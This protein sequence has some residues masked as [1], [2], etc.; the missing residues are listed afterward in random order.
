MMTQLLTSST[1]T[2]SSEEIQKILSKSEGSM[3]KTAQLQQAL[4][5][6]EATLS[7]KEIQKVTEKSINMR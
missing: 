2:N 1:M 3:N 7:R 6:L 5:R 4:A